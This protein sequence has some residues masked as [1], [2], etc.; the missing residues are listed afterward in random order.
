MALQVGDKAPSVL[1]VNQDGNEIKLADYAGKK[2]VLYFYP[3][4]NT[5]GCTAQAC[6]LRDGYADLRKAG[7][8]VIGVSA[9]SEASHQR[10][11]AK[12]NLPFTLIA[13]TDKKLSETFGTWGEK[14]LYGKKF[15]GMFR[16]TFLLDETGTI[17]RI[18]LPKEVNTKDH[19]KQVIG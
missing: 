4:D 8:E 1:G 3:K 2:V 14:S 9:D 7:Y 13:D 15:M 16:T 19:A 6:S 11:I 5:P 10:F 12:Q 18:I 17:T